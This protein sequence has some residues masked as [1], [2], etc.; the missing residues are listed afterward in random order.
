MAATGR[1]AAVW[2]TFDAVMMRLAEDA[3]VLHRPGGVQEVDGLALLL[4][5]G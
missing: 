5:H 3:Q 4:E 2:F 1:G